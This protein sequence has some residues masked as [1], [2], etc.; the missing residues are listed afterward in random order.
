LTLT[1]TS[2][3]L[4]V[5]GGGTSLQCFGGHTTFGTGNGKGMQIGGLGG[6]TGGGGQ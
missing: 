4:V 6:Q 5:G 1:L 2:K 3:T